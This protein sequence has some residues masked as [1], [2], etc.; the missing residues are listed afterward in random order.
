MGIKIRSHRGKIELGEYLDQCK[1]F[2]GY[3]APGLILGGIMVDWA[4]E[5][6]GSFNSLK[7]II[8]TRKCLPD[9]VQILTACTP[10]N[11]K[12]KILDWGKLAIT[13][14]DSHS[15]RGVRVHLDPDKLALYP[16]VKAWAM[17]QKPKKENPL[18]PLIEQMVEGWRNILACR[19]VDVKIIPKNLASYGHPR[20]CIKCGEAFRSGSGD[21]CPGCI[22]SIY[23]DHL[24][25]TEHQGAV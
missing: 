9:A 5:V 6:M 25:S 3:L 8:E 10:G 4:M 17:K 23:T 22:E 16:L 15:Y 18:E 24:P 19:K 12:L 7:A 21:I 13:L 20:L 11:S 1:D 14:F 2:H